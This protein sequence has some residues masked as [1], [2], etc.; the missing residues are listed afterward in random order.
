MRIFGILFMS[1]LLLNSCEKNPIK[2]QPEEEGPSA[3]TDT[4][5]VNLAYGS[6]TDQKLDL[7][8]PANRDA[9][10]KLIILIHGGGWSAGNK[11]ELHFLA[12]RLKNKNFVVANINYRLSTPQNPDNYKMQ[13]DD[14]GSVLSYLK[15][16]SLIYTYGIKEIY[17]AGHSAGAHLSLAYSYSRN[18]DRTIKA[19]AGLASPTNLYT[20]SYYNAALVDQ[21]LIP[22]LGGEREVIKQRYLDCSPYYQVKNA[23]I[24]TI[25][26]SGE[27][28]P[29]TPVSQS[30][31]LISVLST[32]NVPNKLVRYTLAAHDWW[33]T[34]LY[35]DNAIDE[36]TA[37]FRKY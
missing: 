32:S 34:P 6:A 5:I 25:L 11:Q 19:A 26:F 7:H 30:E 33:N 3:K 24:P 20:L 9:N 16:K 14:I 10:S 23:S 2:S 4:V 35:F 27:F 37:W 17:I 1:I 22:Y 15:T 29:I 13:L 28:D 12:K 21:L 36:I 18:A 8:L 31:S